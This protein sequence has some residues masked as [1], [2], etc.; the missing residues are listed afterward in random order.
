VDRPRK[1]GI[2]S[3]DEPKK[4]S[5]KCT[6]YDLYG[7]Y[8][9]T[10]KNITSLQGNQDIEVPRAL[11]TQASKAKRFVM[12]FFFNSIASYLIIIKLILKFSHRDAHKSNTR[13]KKKA[14]S[15]TIFK[16]LQEENI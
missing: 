16:L 2:K 3:S 7:H 11:V 1:N 13:S 15:S 9:I 5:N 12:S 14:C 8:R 10:C 4:R 6:R